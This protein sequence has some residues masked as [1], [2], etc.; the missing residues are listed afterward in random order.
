MERSGLAV[1]ARRRR[2]TD[3]F[4]R[5]YQILNEHS[6]VVEALLYLPVVVWGSHIH[7]RAGYSE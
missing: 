2:K 7:P 6:G 5:R 4:Q 1:Q 3:E